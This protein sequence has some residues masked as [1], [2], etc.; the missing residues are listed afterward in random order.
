M[1]EGAGNQAEATQKMC[2]CIAAADRLK[3]SFA[4][5]STPNASMKEAGAANL[6]EEIR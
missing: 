2:G 5:G 1:P 4:A 6:K 3:G